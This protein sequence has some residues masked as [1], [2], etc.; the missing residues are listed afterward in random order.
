MC[1]VAQCLLKFANLCDSKESFGQAV[2]TK[3]EKNDNGKI[4][5]V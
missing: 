4:F 2:G 1:V 5:V 3:D